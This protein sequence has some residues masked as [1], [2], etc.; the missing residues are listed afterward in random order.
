MGY[1]NIVCEKLGPSDLKTS[2]CCGVTLTMLMKLAIA[3]WHKHPTDVLAATGGPRTL[4]HCS[5]A[6]GDKRHR[7]T[8]VA[9]WAC[10]C[11]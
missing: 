3:L 9:T 8:A 10:W 4:V 11:C 7:H 2:H 1:C 5:P 6:Q